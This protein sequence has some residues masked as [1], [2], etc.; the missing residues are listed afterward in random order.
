M[1][2]HANVDA[3]FPGISPPSPDS[4]LLCG[5]AGDFGLAGEPKQLK[6]KIAPKFAWCPFN[7]KFSLL[8]IIDEC[9]WSTPRPSDKLRIKSIFEVIFD[10]IMRKPTLML[11]NLFSQ[12]WISAFWSI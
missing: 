4:P 1:P 10:Y 11:F 2:H 9:K 12:S 7:Y 8:N 3:L 5:H 6:T